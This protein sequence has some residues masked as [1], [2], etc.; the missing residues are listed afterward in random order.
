MKKVLVILFVAGSLMAGCGSKQLD[1]ETSMEVIKK[2]VGYPLVLDHDIYCSDP[3]HAH[4]L[5]TTGLEKEGLITV[6]Q[7][8][9][10]SDGGKPLIQFTAKAQPY[11]LPTPAKDKTL[12]IQ[13]VK[14]AD[15]DIAEI[16]SIQD[17]ENTKTK[18]VEYT[19]TYKNVTP[20][21]ALISRDFTTPKKHKAYLSFYDGSW[22]I[23]SR[24]GH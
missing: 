3:E 17:D 18:L 4:K 10:L 1:K 13:K 6:Q 11:L 5:Q 15:E 24:L 16:L 23:E 20:F 7:T 12:G 19:T 21:A 9:K 2:N 14:L 8:P 22:K